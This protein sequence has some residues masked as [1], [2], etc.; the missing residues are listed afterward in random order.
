MEIE[1]FSSVPQTQK[2][3]DYVPL[4][5]NSEADP[6]ID[7]IN[8]ILSQ[9][10]NW[11]LES[12][13]VP[14]IKI[15]YLLK[16]LHPII[17]KENSDEIFGYS[18]NESTDI[19]TYEYDPSTKN[20][21]LKNIARGQ[22][23]KIIG[24][25]AEPKN[26]FY[27]MLFINIYA[28]S[29]SLKNLDNLNLLENWIEDYPVLKLIFHGLNRKQV[30]F[31]D[32]ETADET[33]DELTNYCRDLLTLWQSKHIIQYPTSTIKSP[34]PK[35]AYSVFTD[36]VNKKTTELLNITDVPIELLFCYMPDKIYKL[37]EYMKYFG[38]KDDTTEN[39][40]K[41]IKIQYAEILNNNI[42]NYSEFNYKLLYFN[43]NRISK[44]LYGKVYAK[45][46][47]PEKNQV[48]DKLK[49]EDSKNK[50][51]VN[52]NLKI[53][54]FYKGIKYS[55]L[56]LIKEGIEIAAKY[57][58]IVCKHSIAE[59]E[60]ILS[61]QKPIKINE[62][63]SNEYGT[64]NE[65]QVTVCKLCGELFKAPTENTLDYLSG[66]MLGYKMNDN[67]NYTGVKSTIIGM[68][69]FVIRTFVKFKTQPNINRIC[70]YIA[71][72]ILEEIN[73]IDFKLRQTKAPLLEIEDK[74]ELYMLVYVVAVI[75]S[76]ILDNEGDVWFIELARK[77]GYV[78]TKPE[79]LKTALNTNSNLQSALQSTFSTGLNIIISMKHSIMRTL[80]I[81]KLK[82]ADAIKK[83]YQWLRKY[84]GYTSS[85]IQ[86]HKFDDMSFAQAYKNKVM[87]NKSHTEDKYSNESVKYSLDYEKAV[88]NNDYSRT[89]FD[90]KYAWLISE[91]K[92]IVNRILTYNFR[93]KLALTNLKETYLRSTLYF[94]NTI[95]MSLSQIVCSVDG[96]K[97]KWGIGIFNKVGGLSK[98][99][100]GDPSGSIEVVF[101]KHEILDNY[102]LIDFKCDKCNYSFLDLAKNNT[103]ISKKIDLNDRLIKF[104][105][106]Y[107]NRCPVENSHI[108]VDA[109][110][111]KCK[112]DLNTI[113]SK[114]IKYYDKYKQSYVRDV[115][116]RLKLDISDDTELKVSYKTYLENQEKKV[117]VKYGEW[118]INNSV[119]LELSRLAK[120]EYR[121][122]ANL[123]LSSGI[124]YDDFVK[125]EPIKDEDPNIIENR[126]VVLSGYALLLIQIVKNHNNQKVLDNI[127]K[128]F[129]NNKLK[130]IPIAPDLSYESL[131]EHVD[132]ANLSYTGKPESS[133]IILNWICS[134][135]VNICKQNVGSKYYNVYLEIVGALVRILF[136]KEEF[137]S[138]YNRFKYFNVDSIPGVE[139]SI[140][141]EDSG[142][143][144]K[145]ENSESIDVSYTSQESGENVFG[146]N[147]DMESD[148]DNLEGND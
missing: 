90:E 148:N 3:V 5:N 103:E 61:N 129:D 110:C 13:T 83:A 144:S 2:G 118:Q 133:N 16:F 18:I 113:K 109:V 125:M 116:Q 44:D 59:A 134:S 20:L 142:D 15:K 21:R 127:K 126:N 43:R 67:T 53:N 139:G 106:F 63:I 78:K 48:N 141:S 14:E 52:D 27:Y 107:T 128:I 145:S 88:K 46:S 33:V 12:T 22:I 135:L 31:T 137:Y 10:N 26:A 70:I 41:S 123:G 4:I 120:V 68:A 40:I 71:D 28:V 38:I 122:I 79:T 74:I 49:R 19:S 34:Q 115:K 131:R 66:A 73:Y 143:L 7:N 36:E 124:Y 11:I 72:T 92:Q 80:D 108:F 97:H 117:K 35:V 45:L 54:K 65:D 62:T 99:K 87:E 37:Q 56:P 105:D 89:L 111:T 42:K 60:M 76:M 9:H 23:F 94:A 119:A 93:P 77:G 104:Y 82:I 32:K 138:K 30:I 55:S 114:D 39:L 121:H 112:I 86:K 75:I 58:E 47:Q 98:K 57:P 95:E 146:N 100:G 96:G 6:E 91:D 8:K 101:S 69:S 25:A 140:S 81:D 24:F 84:Q 51:D 132:Y 64:V 29:R 102:K 50:V 85:I 136:V 1:V 130:Y 17:A 147:F